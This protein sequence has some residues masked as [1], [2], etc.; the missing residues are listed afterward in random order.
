MESIVA[1]RQRVLVS[2]QTELAE[3]LLGF[4]TRNKYKL[5]DENGVPIGFAA[6]EG[7]GVGAMIGRNFLGKCRACTVHIY[8]QANQPVGRAKKPF[9]WFFHRMD[10]FDGD[11]RIGA[12]QRKF[13]ILN[14]KFV[15]E[16]TQG[17]EVLEIVS[18]LF[19]IWTFKVLRDGA[20]VARISKKWSGMLKEA[21]TDADNFGIE[22]LSDVDVTVRKLLLA[23]VFLVDFTCF[24]NNN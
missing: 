16:D 5:Q 8:D 15:V 18:P 17:R 24:E 22:F 1:G 9:T 10:V 4:E 13:A 7:G 20:E 3:A 21:F 23:A 19:R 12:I 6:E 11:K 14:R 2:Q